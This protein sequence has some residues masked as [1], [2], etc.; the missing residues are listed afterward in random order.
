MK[1]V[2][3]FSLV[4]AFSIPEGDVRST[5]FP[6]P[7][8]S[9]KSLFYIHRSPNP[10]TVIYE[11]NLT[12]KNTIDSEDPVKVYWIRYGEKG[13][14]RDL[15]YLE[16]TFAYGVKSEPIDQLKFRMQFVASKDKTFDVTV[17][18]N[19]QALAMMAI[20][21][22]QSRLTKIF[23]QVAEDGWWPRVAYVEFFGVEDQTNKPTYEK[24]LIK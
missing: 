15:N 12:D 7:P 8:H 5:E 18:E 23:V 14:Q 22:K 1:L 21:G 16:K 17:D 2:A 19:G 4:I 13:Q 11:I 24:M 9:K 20:S 10:N 3:L 6:I